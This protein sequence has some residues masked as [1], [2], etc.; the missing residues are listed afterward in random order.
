MRSKGV[1]D[2]QTSEFVE[3]YETNKDACL[4]AVAVTVPDRAALRRF[5]AL[6]ARLRRD[7]AEVRDREG[8]LHVGHGLDGAR[9]GRARL[10]E[11]EGSLLAREPGLDVRRRAP[12]TPTRSDAAKAPEPTQDVVEADLLIGAGAARPGILSTTDSPPMVAA[13]PDV[14]E[15]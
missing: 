12:S 1:S 6:P 15:M 4:R 8:L 2:S 11:P 3:F 13:G 10:G 14:R 9:V 7:R 5:G